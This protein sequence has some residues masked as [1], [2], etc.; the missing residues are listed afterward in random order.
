VKSCCENCHL[1]VLPLKSHS[2]ELVLSY[3]QKV[4][5]GFSEIL[6]TVPG[7]SEEWITNC[8]PC[9]PRVLF[10]FESCPAIYREGRTNVARTGSGELAIA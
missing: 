3:R 4:L 5:G 1:I 2:D 9:S 6:R 7:L 10:L 8:R